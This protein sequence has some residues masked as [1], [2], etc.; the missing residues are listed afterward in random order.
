MK[1]KTYQVPK[2]NHPWR[3]YKNKVTYTKRTDIIPIKEFL[4]TVVENW[5][6]YEVM[7]SSEFEG[8]YQ[9]KISTM[10]QRKAAMWLMKML[11]KYY[12]D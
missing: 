6:S 1:P 5:Q 7:T 4:S 2:S 10:P 12:V 3:Q 11:K 9:H 8:S